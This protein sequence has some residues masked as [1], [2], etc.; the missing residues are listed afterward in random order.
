MFASSEN[1]LEFDSTIICIYL[2]MRKIISDSNFIPMPWKDILMWRMI[3]SAVKW[4]IQG[5]FLQWY[6]VITKN[7]DKF[8][9]VLI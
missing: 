7:K 9:T 2:V 3:F 6:I 5:F 8:G 4:P 1:F